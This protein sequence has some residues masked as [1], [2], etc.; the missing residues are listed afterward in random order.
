MKQLTALV[1]V[2][3]IA[4]CDAGPD[5]IPTE[6]P[7][8]FWTGP[9]DWPGPLRLEPAGGAAT[10]SMEEQDSEGAVN[11]AFTDGIGDVGEGVPGWLDITTLDVTYRDPCCVSVYFDLADDLPVPIPGRVIYGVVADVDG[12]GTADVRFGIAPISD[13]EHLVWRT[14]FATGHTDHAEGPPYG[15]IA[16]TWYPS[17]HDRGRDGIFLLEPLPGEYEKFRFYVWASM[18][19]NSEVLATDYAPD[20]GWIDRP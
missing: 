18:M 1:A 15:P 4:A 13:S 19:A 16:D 6:P 8:G 10:V 14:D 7:P 3:L 9:S 5:P 2:L 20:Q 11:R 17:Q 12:D